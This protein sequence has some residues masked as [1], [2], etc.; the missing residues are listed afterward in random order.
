[1]VDLLIYSQKVTDEGISYL[2]QSMGKVHSNSL[3]FVLG[4]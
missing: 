3:G 2:K 4:L 1:M